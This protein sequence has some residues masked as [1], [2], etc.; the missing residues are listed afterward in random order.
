MLGM[1][2]YWY[3]K[4]LLS[5]PFPNIKTRHTTEKNIRCDDQKKVRGRERYK[6][7]KQRIKKRETLS[8]GSLLLFRLFAADPKQA[9]ARV[10]NPYTDP[11]PYREA[12]F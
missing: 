9:R 4:S 6:V 7:E 12:D 10:P 1:C 11:N 2:G 3:P 5:L 8:T